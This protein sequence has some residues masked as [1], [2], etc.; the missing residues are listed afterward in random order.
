MSEQWFSAAVRFRTAVEGV[1]GVSDTRSVF[2]FR[3]QDWKSARARALELGRAAEEAYFNGDGQRVERRLLQVQT[4]D[5]LGDEIV[6]GREVYF[7]VVFAEEQSD[8]AD[9]PEESTPSQSGV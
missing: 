6:D 4:L 1:D 2:V 9:R 8:V 7:E 5:L 3:A